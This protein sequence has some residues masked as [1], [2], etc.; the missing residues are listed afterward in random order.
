ME[1]LITPIMFMLLIGGISGY[2]AGNLVKRVSGMAI[3]LGV[4]AFIVIALAYTGNLDLNFDAITANISNVL[5]IIA[6]LGIVALASSV[7]FAASFIAGLFIG[8]RRY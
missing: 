2:F 8:Y 6:P 1:N 3:T 7:P 5:G 4:F